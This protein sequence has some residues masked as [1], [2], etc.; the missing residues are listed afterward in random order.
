MAKYFN[1]SVGNALRRHPTRLPGL[2]SLVLFMLLCACGAYWT[3][4][5]LKPPVRT[6]AAPPPVDVAPVDIS[7][8]VG[9]FGAQGAV[10]VVSNYQLTGV[11]V[12]KKVGESVA[13]LSADGKPAQA[14]MQGKELLPGIVIKEV[15]PNFVLLSKGGILQRVMLP[16]DT[17]PKLELITPAPLPPPGS[18]THN[19]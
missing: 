17:T 3:M 15:H 4:Q 11:V 9:L 14:V 10:T 1:G 8:A 7:Q 5:L 19:Q 6:I 16:E 18:E 13:I 2:V 12:S